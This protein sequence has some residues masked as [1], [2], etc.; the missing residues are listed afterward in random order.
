[1]SQQQLDKE[2]R[3]ISD[4]IEGLDRVAQLAVERKDEADQ[5][6]YA[7]AKTLCKIA[8]Q[9]HEKYKIAAGHEIRSTR[10]QYE[11][12]IRE[13]EAAMIQHK[14]LTDQAKYLNDKHRNITLAV[15]AGKK[16]Y[17][18]SLGA[19]IDA[20][21]KHEAYRLAISRETRHLKKFKKAYDTALSHADKT[22]RR[23]FVLTKAIPDVVSSTSRS[24]QNRRTLIC[25]TADGSSISASKTGVE[26]L[27]G[28][29]AE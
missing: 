5:V 8:Q 14:E 9:A 10:T 25:P 4:Y 11:A 7:Q 21:Q 17:A 13:A 24:K 2:T 1:V 3:M 12:G 23:A 28:A 26:Y 6:L 18:E 19:F 16:Q 15:Q 22:Y 27:P 29:D 20:R